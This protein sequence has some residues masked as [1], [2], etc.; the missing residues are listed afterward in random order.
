MGN[1][2]RRIYRKPTNNEITCAVCPATG[3]GLWGLIGKNKADRK[4]V[5]LKHYNQLRGKKDE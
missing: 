2:G 4:V 1:T 5:C 3:G